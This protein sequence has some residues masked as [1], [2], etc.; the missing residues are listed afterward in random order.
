MTE[1]TDL[2]DGLRTRWDQ[3]KADLRL[4]QHDVSKTKE[5]QQQVATQLRELGY[6]PDGDL[7]GQLREKVEGLNEDV[8]GVEAILA[9]GESALP[10]G[11][12][13]DTEPISSEG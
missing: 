10:E 11:E 6:D 2:L 13:G 9:N 7:D 8:A 5:Q 3:A 12:A 1:T 4:A